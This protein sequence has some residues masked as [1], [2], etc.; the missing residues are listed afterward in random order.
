M[1]APRTS[2]SLKN[3]P[4]NQELLVTGSLDAVDKGLAL[5]PKTD[6][7]RQWLQALREEYKDFKTVD[8]DTRSRN[9][10]NAMAAI[11]SAVAAGISLR[12]AIDAIGTFTGIRRR[13]EVVG[14]ANGITVI[15]DFAHNP[16]GVRGICSITDALPVA[17]RRL[18]CSLLVGL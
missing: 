16:D 14:T 7:E 8:Q 2:W 13:F 12:A 18:L 5:N 15:D 3:E 9:Y 10:R 6:R 1:A 17:G 4:L 11:V